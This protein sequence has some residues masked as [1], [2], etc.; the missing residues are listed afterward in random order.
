MSTNTLMVEATVCTD[1]PD[2]AAKAAEV[3]SRAALGLALD[4]ISADIAMS[5][6]EDAE[7]H[8]G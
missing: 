1:N 8:G 6:I 5:S 3:F 4:G 2:H 7:V